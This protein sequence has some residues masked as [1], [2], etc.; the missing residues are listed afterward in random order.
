MDESDQSENVIQMVLKVSVSIHFP[1]A[2]A[3]PKVGLVLSRGL[4]ER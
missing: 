1:I 2:S 3:G 4:R